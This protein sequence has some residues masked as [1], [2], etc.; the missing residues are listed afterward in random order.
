MQR[1]YSKLVRRSYRTLRHRRIRKVSWLNR[2]VIK[3]FNRDMWRP[4]VRSV[5]IGLSI[6]L[7]CAMLP[8]PF[9]MLL[10]AIFCFIG[11]GNIPIAVAACWVSNPITQVFLMLFQQRVGAKIRGFLDFHWL[12]FIDIQRVIPYFNEPVNLANFA[13]G[14]ATT[15]IFCGI[16]AYPLVFCFYAL[17]PKKYISN[18]VISKKQIY[19]RNATSNAGKII[20]EIFED[21]HTAVTKIASETA[22]LI[23]LNDSIGKPTI[24]GLA[25][26]KTPILFY[27]A[28]IHLHLHDDL[29]FQNVI[30]FNLDEYA[31][32][33]REHPESCWQF[34]HENLFNHID[35]RPEN[36]NLPSGMVSDIEM[37]AHC[38]QYEQDIK[39]A[40]GI[41]LQI[42]GIGRSGHIGF[43]EPGSSKDSL[44]RA[45]LL[46]T[47]TRE[48]AAQSF[49]GIQNVPTKAITMGCGTILAA[50]RI[51]LI[52]WGA[53]KAAIVNEAVNGT[54]NDIVSASYLQEH[55]NASFYIDVEAA[56]ELE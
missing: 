18:P 50:R 28:L 8:I 4:C 22:E 46:N 34:M 10:A 55:P 38:E 37:P 6:G 7:F 33:D 13:V 43:N 31:G 21:S 45:I 15:A 36:I 20:T 23:R 42:L 47:V 5:S 40:G 39:D 32:L 9:Q 53:G 52:A 3:F 19:E 26:G 11:R 35:I 44:T 12:D 25:A 51:V 41:D 2:I 27:R 49:G 56:S 48:D 16:I 54:V 17:V 1:F 30:T 14:V 24:L 29:S